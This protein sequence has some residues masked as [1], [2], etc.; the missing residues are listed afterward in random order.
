MRDKGSRSSKKEMLPSRGGAV[1][2]YLRANRCGMKASVVVSDGGTH[3][4]LHFAAKT[5]RKFGVDWKK[6]NYSLSK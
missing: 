3:D 4:I 5:R 6:S 2:G 1:Q